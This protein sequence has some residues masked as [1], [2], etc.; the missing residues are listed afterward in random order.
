M[1]PQRFDGG[2]EFDLEPTSVSQSLPPRAKW[3]YE[4]ASKIRAGAIVKKTPLP[5]QLSEQ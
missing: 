3:A 5:L 1:R 4:T 2:R